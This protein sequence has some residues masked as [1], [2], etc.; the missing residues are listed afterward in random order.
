MGCD[1]H[2]HIEVKMDGKWHHYNH[3]D[4]GGNYA[5]FGLMAGVRGSS[6][7]FP[8]RGLPTDATEIVKFDAKCW[9]TDGHTHSYLNGKEIIKLIIAMR[10]LF[11]EWK[12]YKC[13]GHLF[14]NDFQDFYI[15]PG[16]YPPE[17][18]DFR[19]IFWFDN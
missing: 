11:I 16:D 5:L 7:L 14:G 13:F 12:A 10:K 8:V 3:P 6:S 4:V 18:Q 15:Y 9:E 17:I 1:I 2:L 19:F